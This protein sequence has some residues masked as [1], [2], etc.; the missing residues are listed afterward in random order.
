[1]NVAEQSKSSGANYV[2]QAKPPTVS[3]VGELPPV[4]N[5]DGTHSVL[6]AIRIDAQP[7]PKAL[8]VGVMKSDV[9]QLKDGMVASSFNVFPR[10][11]GT[12]FGATAQ[13]ADFYVQKVEMPGAGEYVVS[14]KVSSPDAKA[15]I[16]IELQ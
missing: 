9:A 16:A 1:M 3:I 5:P 13:N 4:K 14:C 2:V 12:I 7:L 8:L 15:R 6:L 11:G 10:S